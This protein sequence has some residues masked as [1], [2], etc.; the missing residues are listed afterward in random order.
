MYR[1]VVWTEA[2]PSRKRLRA[3]DIAI[4]NETLAHLSPIGWE[5]INLTGDYTWK[6]EVRLQ[7]GG[8]RPLRPF[9]A[10]NE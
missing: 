4:E 5:H 6:S 3:H 10:A 9:V 2:C 8:F 1:S 7:K